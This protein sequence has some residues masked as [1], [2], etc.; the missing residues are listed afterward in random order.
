[1]TS[2]VHGLPAH[3]LWNHFVIVLMPLT[4][5]LAVL[6]ALWPAARRRLVWL[7]LALSLV[8]AVLTLLTVDSGGWLADRMGAPGAPGTLNRHLDL[9][10]SAGYCAAGLVVIAALPAVIHVRQERGHVVSAVLRIVVAAVVIAGAITV[11]VQVYRIGE[12]GARAAWGDFQAAAEPVRAVA[13]SAGGG[14]CP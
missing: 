3:I 5:A 7:V 14:V 11:S 9:G 13:G 10:G 8:D 2:T 12:S 6:C 4:A 1:M